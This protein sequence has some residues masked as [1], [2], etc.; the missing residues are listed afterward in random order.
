MRILSRL[1]DRRGAAA[2]PSAPGL[3]KRVEPAW[4]PARPQREIPE[5]IAPARGIAIALGIGA[6]AW[7]ALLLAI[8]L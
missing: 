8:S 1:P 5:G 2:A 3:R 4:L 6:L 7:L